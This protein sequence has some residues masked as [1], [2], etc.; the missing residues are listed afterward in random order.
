MVD[1]GLAVGDD[2]RA[3][4]ADLPT[5]AAAHAQ[6]L[7]Y[8]G[9]T[10]VVLL[11]LTGAAAAAHADILQRAAKAGRLVTLKVGKRHKDIRVHNR[12]TDLRLFD[13]FDAH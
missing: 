3:V 2:R 7:L 1:N 12:L 13:V 8:M 11:H 5:L 10:G 6:L 4:G 9:L